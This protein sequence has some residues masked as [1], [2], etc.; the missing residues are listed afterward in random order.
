MNLLEV[1]FVFIS[2][3][4]AGMIDQLITKHGKRLYGLCKTL[5]VNSYDADDLYQETWLKVVQHFSRYDTT[6]DFEPWVTRICVNTYRNRARRMNNSPI[7]D[8]FSSSEEKIAVME[9]VKKPEEKDFSHIHQEINKLPEKLRIT[10]ILFYFK[11]MDINKVSEIL[12]I[13]QGTVKSRLN[14]ARNI[15]KEVLNESDL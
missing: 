12:K 2:E 11:D 7:F 15:L 8:G 9:N 13:P 1:S 3:G 5:C 10:I 6:K 14:K 4:G